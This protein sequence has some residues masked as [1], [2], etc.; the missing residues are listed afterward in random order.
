[1]PPH[2]VLL[3]SR[4]D[5]WILHFFEK[6]TAMHIAWIAI[7]SGLLQEHPLYAILSCGNKML[8]PDACTSGLPTPCVSSSFDDAQTTHISARDL[9][10]MVVVHAVAE[11]KGH[12]MRSA[13]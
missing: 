10:V 9:K 3:A 2:A 12:S 4:C 7:I 13:T 6:F 8:G 11:K 5:G 1:M